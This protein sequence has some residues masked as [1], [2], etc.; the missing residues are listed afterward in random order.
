[1]NT[2]E[3]GDCPYYDAVS[4]ECTRHNNDS[5]YLNEIRERGD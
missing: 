4:R 5:C 2:C 3:K 1:M